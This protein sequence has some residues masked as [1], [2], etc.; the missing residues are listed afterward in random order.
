MLTQRPPARLVSKYCASPR[1]HAAQLVAAGSKSS[2]QA[3]SEEDH[4][5]KLLAAAMQGTV[6]LSSRRA[7][8]PPPGPSGIAAILLACPSE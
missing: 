6:S 1:T 2:K 3:A 7:R 8:L 5:A 4:R